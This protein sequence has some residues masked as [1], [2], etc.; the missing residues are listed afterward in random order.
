MKELSRQE[1]YSRAA[2]LCSKSEKCVSD[3]RKKLYDWHVEEEEHEVVIETLIENKY[4]DEERF[5]EYYVRDKF[6]FNGWGK[7][8]IRHHLNQKKIPSYCIEKAISAIN[9]EEYIHNL[10]KALN[11]KNKTIKTSDEFERRQKLMRFAAGRGY[12]LDEINQAL[13]E[14]FSMSQ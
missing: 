12:T 3:I 13:D 11:G 10:L 8:K 2:A 14:I 1:A 6:R 5:A 4:I 7:I 9:K